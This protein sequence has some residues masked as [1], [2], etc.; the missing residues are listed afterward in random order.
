[1]KEILVCI[2]LRQHLGLYYQLGSV[3]LCKKKHQYPFFTFIFRSYKTAFA[4]TYLYVIENQTTLRKFS[5]VSMIKYKSNHSFSKIGLAI[6][7]CSMAPDVYKNNVI[8]I[9]YNSWVLKNCETKTKIIDKRKN[10][11]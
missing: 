4:Y 9:T 11:R 3:C 7:V 6:T 10:R 2:S 1:M 5:L 8:K